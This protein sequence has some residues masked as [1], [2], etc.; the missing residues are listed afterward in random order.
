LIL[1]DLPDAFAEKHTIEQVWTNLIS[2]ALKYTSKTPDTTVE[3]SAKV[4]VGEIQYIIKD[5]GSG[6][7]MKYYDKIFG[8]FQRLHTQQEFEGTG[9]GLAI[10]EKL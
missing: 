3:I 1:H 7:D 10:V 8:V 5:N 2:N 4:T 6:F 9:V